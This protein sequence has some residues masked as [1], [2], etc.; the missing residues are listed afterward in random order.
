MR[1]YCFICGMEGSEIDAEGQKR[2]IQ[3]AFKRHIKSEHH[4][5]V[6]CCG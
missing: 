1:D 3:K 4:M 6:A 5:Y 2:G